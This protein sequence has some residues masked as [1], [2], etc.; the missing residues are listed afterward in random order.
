M[1]REMFYKMRMGY[2]GGYHQHRDAALHH[3]FWT[4][5]MHVAAIGMVC[6]IWHTQHTKRGFR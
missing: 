4:K 5:I 1:K 6:V 3:L 2:A